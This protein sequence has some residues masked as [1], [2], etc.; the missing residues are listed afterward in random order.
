MH[1]NHT[2]TAIP[3]CSSAIIGSSWST[4]I[5]ALL[6]EIGSSPSAAAIEDSSAELGSF[7]VQPLDHHQL[8][9]A[10]S[11][12]AAIEDSRVEIISSSTAA[13]AIGIIIS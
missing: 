11:L 12:S 10:H 7:Y 1:S 9:L 4:T 6:A 8:K 13:I 2:C 3:E 5:S